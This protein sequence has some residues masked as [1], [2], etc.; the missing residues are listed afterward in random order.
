[1]NSIQE[2]THFMT[3]YPNCMKG[4]ECEMQHV[5]CMPKRGLVMQPDGVWDG[6]QKYEFLINGIS[7]SGDAMELNSCQQCG[8]LQV[9]LNKAPITHKC[10][11]QGSVSLSMAEGEL[12]AACKAAQIMLFFM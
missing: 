2:L 3:A 7:D 8:G 1:M 6:G 10:K 12:I 5:L 9:F 4:M 11:M